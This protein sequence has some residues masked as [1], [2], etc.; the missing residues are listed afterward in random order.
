MRNLTTFVFASAALVF[1]AAPL[2]GAA[3][4]S[5]ATLATPLGV[6]KS[7]IIDGKIWKCTDVNCVAPT[8]SSSQP[9]ARECARAVKVLGKVTAY[10]R[11]GE[12]LDAAGLSTCNAG[13]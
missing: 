8:S 2:A 7:I 10:S 6:S 1:T 9:L 12:S 4:M 3:A 11:D 5:Q 13:A